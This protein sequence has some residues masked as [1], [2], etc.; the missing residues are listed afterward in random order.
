ME[1]LDALHDPGEFGGVV[2][3]GP[4]VRAGGEAAAGFGDLALYLGGEEVVEEL[5][6][7]GR[8]GAFLTRPAAYG[9]AKVDGLAPGLAAGK[10]M[11]WFGM[12]F[13]LA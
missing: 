10:K 1:D 11:P 2:V 12:D 8:V 3:G 7:L 6:G 4:D 5:L 9:S 13:M